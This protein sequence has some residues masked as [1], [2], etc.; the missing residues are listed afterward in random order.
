M[1]YPPIQRRKI[2]MPSVAERIYE[3]VKP[4]PESLALEALHF[5]EY[6]NSKTSERAEMTAFTRAQ[7][8]AMQHVWDNPDDEVW[9]DIKTL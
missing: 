6:L 4:L 8:T 2:T 9:N 5:V 7:E 3:I 1:L